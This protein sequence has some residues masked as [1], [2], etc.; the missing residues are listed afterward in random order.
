MR[1]IS[2]EPTRRNFSQLRGQTVIACRYHA[3]EAALEL[4]SRHWDT[5]GGNESAF[6]RLLFHGVDTFKRS[7]GDLKLPGRA[8]VERYSSRDVPG[9]L[10]I[11][12]VETRVES[13]LGAP[14]HHISLIFGS[15]HGR[16]DFNYRSVETWVRPVMVEAPGGADE[17]FDAT[18][19]A[20]VDYYDPFKGLSGNESRLAPSGRGPLRLARRPRPPPRRHVLARALR[21]ADVGPLRRFVLGGAAE[22]LSGCPG[23]RPPGL[24][25]IRT[26]PTRASGPSDHGF[27][28]RGRRE[29]G[30]AAAGGGARAAPSAPTSPSPSACGDRAT[31]DRSSPSGRAG[32]RGRLRCLGSQSTRSAR[33]ASATD[34][35][36]GA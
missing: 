16:C 1:P 33:G 28:T 14:R 24:P 4:I 30:R 36:L 27:V 13:H 7:R 15:S 11:E 23:G 6:L 18:T 17:R 35:A 25:P 5:F 26:C 34:L 19:G 22:G 29:V 21:R 20:P 31:S 10:A 12:E 9:T 32:A 8:W 2:F 3:I